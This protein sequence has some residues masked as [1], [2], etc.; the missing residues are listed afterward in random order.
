M[1]I[2][3]N[4]CIGIWIPC[5]TG[6]RLHSLPEP[7][8]CLALP[9]SFIDWGLSCLRSLSAR[10]PLPSSCPSRLPPSLAVFPSFRSK[11]GEEIAS[12]ASAS[13]F[14]HSVRWVEPDKYPRSAAASDLTGDPDLPGCL[15]SQP[16]AQDV[17]LSLFLPVLRRLT[18][19][20]KNYVSSIFIISYKCTYV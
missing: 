8:F 16:S 5:G 11:G 3:I 12:R 6:D 10:D 13:A 7:P 2:C 20:H 1:C 17:A 4:V 18:N 9:L 15:S 19:W 14:C